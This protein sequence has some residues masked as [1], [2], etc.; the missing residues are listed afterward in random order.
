VLPIGGVKDKLLA[1]HR[2]GLKTF[3]L[4]SKNLRDLYEVDK[5]I[6]EAIE[7][8]PVDNVGEVLDRALVASDA[9]RRRERG[10]GFVLPITASDVLGPINAN[11]A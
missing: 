8:V 5:E 10:A 7:V 4:P 3:I 6:L 1:A 11:P 9:P 2:S